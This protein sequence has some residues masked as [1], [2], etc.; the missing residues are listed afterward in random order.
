MTSIR[1]AFDIG[2]GD[3]SRV[4]CCAVSAVITPKFVAIA[5]AGDCRAVVG[6]HGAAVEHSEVGAHPLSTAG[7]VAQAPR[8]TTEWSAI[9]LSEDHNC[10]HDGIQEELRAAHPGEDDIV[11]CRSSTSCYVKGRLQPTRALGDLYLK[12]SE[13]NGKYGTR[14]YGRHI[15][16]PYTPPYVTA[17]PEVQ[18]HATD[19]V[20]DAFLLLAC[21]GVWVCLLRKM[22]IALPAFILMQ[23]VLTNQ[24]AIEFIAN[25]SGDPLTVSERLVE[26]VLEREGAS[27]GLTID[28]LKAVSLFDLHIKAHA[29]IWPCFR[30]DQPGTCAPEHAR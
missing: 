18:V 28:Q 1:P 15:K 6:R 16:P 29:R 14:L 12:Y 7:T 24:E 26:F 2:F 13:F 19:Q 27:K 11:V 4:G 23:D 8:S 10:R 3:V 20:R 25:D 30:A 21:D 5:N 17:T 22:C 9:C